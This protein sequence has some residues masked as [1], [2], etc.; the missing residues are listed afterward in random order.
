VNASFKAILEGTQAA[1]SRQDLSLDDNVLVRRA[2]W[3]LRSI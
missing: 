2:S 1:T 3:K